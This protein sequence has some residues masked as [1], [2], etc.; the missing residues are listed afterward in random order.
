M[1]TSQAS[2]PCPH[3]SILCRLHYSFLWF[4]FAY[5]SILQA[6]PCLEETKPTGFLVLKFHYPS[7]CWRRKVFRR[8]ACSRLLLK[9]KDCETL[10]IISVL[11]VWGFELWSVSDAAYGPASVKTFLMTLKQDEWLFK[12]HLFL[13]L[14]STELLHEIGIQG[15]WELCGNHCK[16]H[17]A[18]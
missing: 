2:P 6:W 17:T 13:S 10:E 14:L 5:S 3:S 11:V 18:K 8:D 7:N 1:L 4:L 15:T 12:Y 9:C 16:T